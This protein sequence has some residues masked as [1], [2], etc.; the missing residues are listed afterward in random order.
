MNPFDIL[1]SLMQG[2]MRPSG[3][4]L[5]RTFGNQGLGGPGAMP[6]RGPGPM[7][8]GPPGGIPGGG[9]GGGIFDML[10]KVA[11][12]VLSGGSSHAGA[13]GAPGAQSG[14][15]LPFDILKT[16]GGS[17][18]GGSGGPVGSG[19]GPGAA[20]AGAMSV[21]GTLAAQALEY[22]KQMMSGAQAQAGPAAPKIDLDDATAVIAGMRRPANR[23]EEQQLLDIATLTIRAMINAAKAD[24]R[25]D[26]QEA[27]RLVGKMQEDGVTDEERRFVMD[28]MRKPMETESIV[29]AVPNQQVAAQ[30]YAASLMAI[31]VDTDAERRYMEELA[32]KL[33]MDRPVVAYLHQAV[34][35]S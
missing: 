19:A 7:P 27:E 35:L 18:F 29:R 3:G 8:G 15:G 25:I 26:A 23:Q 6:G 9:M 33:G 16:I 21:F 24:G 10:S 31:E 22:A 17:I 2:G 28:E 30:I 1:G 11:G 32:H 20:G 13:G 34:G 4:R 14:G 5:E 12:S